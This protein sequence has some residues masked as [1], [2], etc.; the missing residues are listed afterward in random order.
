MTTMTTDQV[1]EKFA[2]QV[3]GLLER[4]PD[5]RFDPD[6]Y[7]QV[8]GLAGASAQDLA[9]HYH[10][11]G[12]A[13]GLSPTRYADM[14]KSH[15]QIDETLRGLVNNPDLD[16]LVTNKTPDALELLCELIGLGDPV[17]ATVSDFSGKWYL[18]AN[19][20]LKAAKV[21]PVYHYLCFGAKEGRKN[22]GDLREAHH[23]G[24]REFRSDWPTC[25][26]C[27]HEMSRTGAPIVGLDLA[28]EASATHN[29]VVAALRDGPLLNEFKAVACEVA[30]TENPAQ[31]LDEILS[32]R[33]GAI[34]FAIINSIVSTAFIQFCLMK[35]IPSASYVHEYKQYTYPA[36]PHTF[37]PLFSD[38]MVFSSHH[39]KNSWASRFLDIEFDTEKDSVIVP[40]RPFYW[41]G[42]DAAQQAA[43]RQRLSRIVGRDL[44]TCRIICGAGH[45]QWRKGTDLFAIAAQICRSRDPDT[46]FIWIGHG[47][48]HD[49]MGFGAYMAH[50][51]EEIGVGNRTG[52]L[53]FLEAG[54]AYKDLLT[55]A[56][57]MFLSSRLDPLP[58]VVF[59]ALEYGCKIVQFD[60][61]TGFGDDIYTQTGHV[62]SVEYGNPDAALQELLKLPR[63]SPTR[64]SGD[65]PEFH[66][67]ETI[68]TALQDR[69]AR[70]RY[71]VAGA[72]QIDEPIMFTADDAHAQARVLERNKMFTY[73]R[74]RLWRDLDDV[75][76]E[77][78]ASDNWVHRK[79]RLAGYEPAPSADLPKF[80]LHVHAHY[81]DELAAD[82]RVYPMYRHAE[83]IVVTTDTDKKADAIRKIMA[84]HELEPEI[85]LMPNKGRDI[86]PFMK[87]FEPG[88]AAGSD[89]LWCHIHQKKS[90]T[91]TS[92]G[93]KWRR[94]LLRILFG[95]GDEVSNALGL[96]ARDG[97]GLVAPFDPH[98]LGWDDSR[99]LL[100]KFAD[101]LPG[102]FPDNPLL[103][104]V[105]NMFWVR[106]S[107]VVAMNKL[108]GAD[109]IWPG[110]PIANDGT[111][112]HLIE[113]LWPTMAA[114]VG[115][116][117]VFVHKLDEKRI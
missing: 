106:R 85:V 11:H 18:E 78:R 61:G 51:L 60:G 86:L 102:P 70:Q 5:F 96:L 56:D 49:E 100:P 91:S 83:R 13:S 111:E 46:V 15:P 79:L 1:W 82:M 81:T 84:V 88:G 19:T 105:G 99:R 9:E 57:A 42:V 40:Q 7:A 23:I 16:P 67:F 39:V 47:I 43:A 73:G 108:F 34:D 113:R 107:V 115:L 87:L 92:G 3:P 114:A 64:S 33:P 94:F 116:E 44:S 37:I 10:N 24:A 109:Y 74:R 104:P 20:D 58:N 77:V 80:S 101:R 35:K 103:F 29:V 90:L 27:V 65:K 8:A 21:D 45:S 53:F 41:G 93:D 26:I 59:D 2:A 117:S 66:L 14:V 71:F 28:R 38:L 72:S 55:A 54:P 63:K 112:Y 89:D 62:V 76:S 48:Q 12:A 110:E 32:A 30:I 17:D 50:H 36:Y 52:N 69:I 98:Y 68:R 25:L 4:R 97:V 22:L 95:K 6:Y 75:T 31:E